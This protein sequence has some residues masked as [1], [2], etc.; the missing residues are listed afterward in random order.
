MPTPF[1]TANRYD[2][3]PGLAQMAEL[4]AELP[5][6]IQL[7]ELP[8]DAE[9]GRGPDTV[10]PV[11][12]GP[13]SAYLYPLGRRD[14]PSPVPAEPVPGQILFEPVLGGR[15]TTLPWSP[16][17]AS[18]NPP[19]ELWSPL[20]AWLHI[21]Q[22]RSPGPPVLDQSTG[23]PDWDERLLSLL[24]SREILVQLADGYYRV[25]VFPR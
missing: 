23:L 17:L 9:P 18:A 11:G 25:R 2:T 14:R 20:T 12:P 22:G 6:V 16:A 7:P 4:F 13:M 5:P 8:T 21:E 15:A 3:V 19:G 10:A 1:N 24:Q